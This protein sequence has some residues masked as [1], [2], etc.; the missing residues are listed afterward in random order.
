[1]K[2]IIITLAS[3]FLLVLTSCQTVGEGSAEDVFNFRQ[4]NWSL[5]H[6]SDFT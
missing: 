3:V 1:M 2:K 4:D 6:D 5:V